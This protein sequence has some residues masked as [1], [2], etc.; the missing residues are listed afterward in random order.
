MVLKN[1]VFD[2]TTI[3]NVNVFKHKYTRVNYGQN[4]KK[5]NAKR[6]EKTV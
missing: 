3:Y 4:G 5:T 2:F 1:T 6:T